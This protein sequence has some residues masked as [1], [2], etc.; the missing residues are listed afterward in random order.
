M[1]LFVILSYFI[2]IFFIIIICHSQQS[3]LQNERVGLADKSYFI[4][5]LS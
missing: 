4:K 2:F 5:I 1:T 3:L